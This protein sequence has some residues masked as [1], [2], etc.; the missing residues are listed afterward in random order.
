MMKFTPLLL[1]AALS[2]AIDS[3][4]YNGMYFRAIKT[5][6]THMLRAIVG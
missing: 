3:A 4:W 1:V 5:V 6:T 2:Y